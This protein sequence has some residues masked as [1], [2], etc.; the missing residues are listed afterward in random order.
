MIKT[1]QKLLRPIAALV[2]AVCASTASAG[3]IE[4]SSNIA[5][6]TTNTW[7]ATNTYL[8]KQVIYVETN[9]VLRIEPGTVIKGATGLNVNATPGIPNA[10]SGLVVTRGGRLFAEGTAARPII[11]TYDGD[12]VNDPNDIP[13]YT[14]G[15]WGGVVLLGT[16][17]INSAANAAG[18]VATPRYEVYEGLTDLPQHRFGGGTND[19]ES[20]GVLRYVSIR[21][22]G[23]TLSA[24]REFNGLSLGGVGRGTIVEH[25]EVF[26]S[27]DDGFEWWGG[28]VNAK[29][30]V[31]AFCED[32]SFDYDQGYRGDQQFLF[33]IQKPS[34]GLIE[35]GRGIETDGDLNNGNATT[36]PNPDQ[37]RTI[38]RG[39]NLT[40]IGP[41]LGSVN[42]AV[43]TRDESAPNLFNSVFSEFGGGIQ[44][45]NDGLFEIATSG[46]GDFR[47][48]IFH[49]TANSFSNANANFLFSD[50][51]RRNTNTNP[52]L[53][54]VSRTNNYGL[55]PRPQPGS[56]ALVDVAATPGNGFFALTCYRGAFGSA[57]WAEWS[58]LVD[59][60]VF[61]TNAIGRKAA[62]KIRVPDVTQVQSA[63]GQLTIQFLTEPDV[64]YQLQRAPNVASPTVW[65]EVARLRG[66]GGVVEFVDTAIATQ[67][68]QVY[69][70]RLVQE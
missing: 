61:S 27:S 25:V 34:S 42:T 9:A 53:V 15:Q 63:S 18:N 32:D 46:E 3:I 40:V 16:A 23:N 57:N 1:I 14:S 39:Y 67:T 51:N 56:P 10:V 68:N 54:S 43:I 11:F 8:L 2:A 65:T 58:G 37:P 59:L 41:G 22:A 52:L 69:R 55:D 64:Y 33:A 30:L 17:A 66:T 21:H 70:V 44:I 31:A 36:V 35:E 20:S 5:A 47:H 48:N 26:G 19:T 62:S 50:A 60:G 38:W 24:N 49:V 7:V 12:D 45:D 13:L 29:Y 4:V 28:T 6:G